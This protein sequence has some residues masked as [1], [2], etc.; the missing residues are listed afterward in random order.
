MPKAHSV[1]AE[2]IFFCKG[3]DLALILRLP[4]DTEGTFF[5][6]SDLSLNSNKKKKT[7]NDCANL[8]RWTVNKKRNLDS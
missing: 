6:P 1:T 7:P 5:S 8:P 3:L 4:S 2:M